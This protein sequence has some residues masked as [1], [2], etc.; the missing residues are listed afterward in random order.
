[1]V[2]RPR[3][4]PN[5]APASSTHRPRSPGS[6][7]TDTRQP[8]PSD[9][10]SPL[11][12]DI[13]RRFETK[14][15][16]AGPDDCWEWTGSRHPRYPYGRLV[17]GGRAG[18]VEYAHRLAWLH[19]VGPIP[20]GLIVRHTCDNAP[21]CNPAHLLLGTQADNCLDM[22]KRRRSGV[23]KLT[24]A[25]IDDIASRPRG[26]GTRVTLAAEFGIH[27]QTITEIRAGR[28]KRLR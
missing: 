19:W 5:S 13:A 8:G 17:V 11:A 4:L 10:G 27:P 9:I 18:K 21:C 3:T 24:L 28:W 23:Q 1:M 25:Q 12:P 2:A 22:V 6:Q 14:I 15:A 20:D 26:Y 16:Y 7:S